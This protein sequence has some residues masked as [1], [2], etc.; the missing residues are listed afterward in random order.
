MTAH[1]FYRIEIDNEDLT[2]S[3]LYAKRKRCTTAKGMDRQHERIVNQV[4]E[5]IRDV[6]GWKRLSVAVMSPDEVSTAGLA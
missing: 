5:G 3:V 1:R 6:R 4:V 2:T